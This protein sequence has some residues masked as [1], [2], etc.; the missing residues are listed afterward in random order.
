M[1]PQYKDIAD[2]FVAAYYQAYTVDRMSVAQFYQ[3]D[4][5]MT[6][7]GDQCQGVAAIADRYSVSA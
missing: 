5:L 6:F 1:N 7:E 2:A 4:S 3:D